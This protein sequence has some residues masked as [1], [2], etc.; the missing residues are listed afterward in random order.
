MS[1]RTRTAA[2]GGRNFLGGPDYR[3]GGGGGDVFR[4]T[5]NCRFLYFFPAKDESVMTLTFGCK[6][7]EMLLNV[8]QE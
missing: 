4:V 1:P 2:G 6:P 8:E 3:E 7:T 5:R